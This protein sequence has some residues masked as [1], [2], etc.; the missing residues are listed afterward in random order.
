MKYLL[1]FAF[2]YLSLPTTFAFNDIQTNWYKDSIIE[3]KEAG[4]INGFENGDFLPRDSITR[5]ELLKII[6]LLWK[7]EIQ[8]PTQTCFSDVAL[9][10]WYAKY[11][12]SASTLEIAKGYED[13]TFSPNG[14]ITVLEALAFATRAFKVTLPET[15]EGENWYDK[16]ITYAH[17]NNIIPNNA[18]TKDT[19]VS[20]GQAVEIISNI[21]KISAGE[22]LDYKSA[23][24]ESGELLQSKNTLTVDG[25]ERSYLLQMP[26]NYDPSKAYPLVIGVHGRT[27][28]NQMVKDYMG[29]S[30]VGKSRGD[31]REV[32]AIYPAGSGKWPYSWEWQANLDF[33]DSMLTQ[34]TQTLCVDRSQVHV[35]GHS[36]GAHYANKLAC[37]RGDIFASLSAVWGGGYGKDCTWPVASII[38][39]RPD[40]H[41]EAFSSGKSAVEIRKKIN[42][43]TW[44]PIT[45]EFGG[46]SCQVWKE[47]SIGNPVAFCTDYD[48]LLNDPHSWPTIHAEGMYEF[49]KWA[50]GEE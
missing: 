20:R 25:V 48:T 43:C 50:R 17:T 13:A 2:F 22:T 41:L 29:L 4:I 31:S 10:Q 11:I 26:P 49:Q 46:V 7:I 8:E 21:A 24:C 32:I 47:C 39:H 38:Y 6:L 28:S 36:M 9:T 35:I 44:E 40:D 5:A 3:L 1:F 45:K 27:N 12:C 16:Y 37:L 19:L 30:R 14:K 33:I 15:Q 23:G 18:Y 42:Q 34:V